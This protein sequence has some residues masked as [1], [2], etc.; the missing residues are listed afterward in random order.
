MPDDA[1]TVPITIE[2]SPEIAEALGDPAT[3]ARLER[4]IRLTLRPARVETL[5]ET[6]GAL[7]AEAHRRGLTDDIVDAELAAYNAERRERIPPPT[8]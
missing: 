5:F 1:R 8:T 3:R 6:I 2:V 7:K 4:L